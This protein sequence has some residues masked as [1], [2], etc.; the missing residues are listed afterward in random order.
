MDARGLKSGSHILKHCL[1]SH[2]N[3]EDFG[4]ITFSMRVLRF[5][6]TAFERQIYESVMIQENRGHIIERVNTTD[7]V[8]PGL[9]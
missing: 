9:P 6:R 5:P 7:A 2:K 4:G 1:E 3:E 8:F